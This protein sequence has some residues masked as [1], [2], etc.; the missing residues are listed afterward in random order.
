[1]K[2]TQLLIFLFFTK[3]AILSAQEKPQILVFSKTTRYYHQSI[4][5]GIKAIQTLGLENNFG[6]D[7]TTDES[8]F[9][10]EGLRKYAALLF[11][12][13]SGELLDT[14]QKMS[15]KRF[16]ESGKG[17]IGVHAA[18]TID[19]N[20]TWYGHLVGAVFINHP[21]PQKGI[22]IVSDANDASTRHLPKNWVWEDEWYN[23]RDLQPDIHVLLIADETSYTGGTNGKNHPLAW[24]HNYDGG[25]S[26]YT[27][28]GH[29]SGAYTNPLF[30]K[31]LLGGIRYAI[32]DTYSGQKK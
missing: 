13:P 14:L 25:R 16:I 24:F 7:T 26:F 3:M 21:A 23:L 18:S 8:K 4:P 9:T 5:A 12:S 15:L 19:K 29:F 6:V 10:D 11:L 28:L 30:L 27:A 2:F 1:M 20:W 32:G 31:H 22:V 17:Y